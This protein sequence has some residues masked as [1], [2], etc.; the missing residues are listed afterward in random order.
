MKSSAF[1]DSDKRMGSQ[2]AL[3]N[4]MSNIRNLFGPDTAQPVPRAFASQ[5]MTFSRQ[6]DQWMGFWTTELL[7]K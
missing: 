2:I 3:L 5:L 7:S 4:I 1:T 6:I